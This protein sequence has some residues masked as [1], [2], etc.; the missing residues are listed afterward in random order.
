VA[1][2]VAA[3]EIYEAFIVV[4]NQK[5]TWHSRWPRQ[6]RFP[7]V[8]ASVLQAEPASHSRHQLAA[9]L[10]AHF[11]APWSGAAT[12]GYDA[13]PCLPPVYKPTDV[14]TSPPSDVQRIGDD[15]ENGLAQHHSVGVHDGQMV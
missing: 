2:Q 12:P 8:V 13:D 4:H 5:H 14:H 7:V 6:T 11:S 15:V 3:E 10:E 9:D 1:C